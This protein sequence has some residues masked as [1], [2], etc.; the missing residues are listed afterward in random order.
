[1]IF[2]GKIIELYSQLGNFLKNLKP[3]LNSLNKETK[4]KS[5]MLKIDVPCY[6]HSFPRGVAVLKQ[7][8]QSSKI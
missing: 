3:T 2:L 8:T 7:V 6:F 4:S 5:S 1:M